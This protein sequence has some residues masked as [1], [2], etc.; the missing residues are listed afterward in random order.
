M[1][2]YNRINGT[3]TSESP[4]LLKGV[5]RDDWGFDGLVMT[6]WF[7]GRDAVAQMKAGNEL[8][9]PGTP[10]QRK[11]L[12][13]ALESGALKEEV[14]DRNVALILDVVKRTR[15]VPEARPLEHARPEGATRR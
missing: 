13:D 9:M 11:A 2:S 4:E 8:L 10:A 15:F 5:L 3:Y 1:S 12:M 14:L 6:D 7:G